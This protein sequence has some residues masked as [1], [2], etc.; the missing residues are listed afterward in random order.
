MEEKYIKIIIDEAKKAS[1]HDEVPVGAII[2][3]KNKIISK[4]HN[5]VE[6]KKNSILHAEIVAISKASRKLKNWRLNDC[7]MYVTLEPC[8]MCKSAIKL[9][10]IKKV[11]YLL[12]KDK[13][14]NNKASYVF[15]DKYKNDSL[16]LL[17]QF[18]KEKR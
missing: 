10:R 6:K 13:K 17:Q 14:N 8:E 16:K 2:V 3:K 9:C 15:L 1:K 11:Y 7:E 5:I 12:K 18:F 4:A